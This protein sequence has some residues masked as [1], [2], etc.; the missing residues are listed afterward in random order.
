[1]CLDKLFLSP[2]ALRIFLGHRMNIVNHL[3]G[4]LSFAHSKEKRLHGSSFAEGRVCFDVTPSCHVDGTGNGKL[5]VS[6]L[7]V[8]SCEFAF[9]EKRGY[10]ILKIFS[11]LLLICG[12]ANAFICSLIKSLMLQGKGISSVKKMLLAESFKEQMPY[13]W[14]LRMKYDPVLLHIIAILYPLTSYGSI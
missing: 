10:R 2:A 5:A 9:G 1:M 12:W 11:L 6:S 8:I 3:N 4:W 14:L 13:C 7:T